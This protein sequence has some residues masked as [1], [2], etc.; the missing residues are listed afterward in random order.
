MT[1]SV[2]LARADG[3][4]APIAVAI[5]HRVQEGSGVKRGGSVVQTRSLQASSMV[6]EDADISHAAPASPRTQGGSTGAVSVDMQ[7]GQV[8]RCGARLQKSRRAKSGKICIE[9]TPRWDKGEAALRAPTPH[10]RRATAGCALTLDPS[11]AETPASGE[12]F[13]LT[14]HF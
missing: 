3:Q 12:L 7:V 13:R 6:A 1:F 10:A 4:P 2:G 11:N 9:R 14:C 5:L 8:S